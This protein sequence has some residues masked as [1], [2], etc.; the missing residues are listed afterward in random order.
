ME[1]KK[2]PFLRVPSEMLDNMDKKEIRRWAK[3][4]TL[5]RI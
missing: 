1:K 3:Y 5:I 4:Y 2:K